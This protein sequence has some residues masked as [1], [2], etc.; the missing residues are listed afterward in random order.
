MYR[1]IIFEKYLSLY[2]FTFKILVV[3]M[4]IR[5]MCFE[6]V[7]FYINDFLWFSAP[8]LDY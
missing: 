2:G 8:G 5:I 7:L 3:K 1:I 4:K 6:N